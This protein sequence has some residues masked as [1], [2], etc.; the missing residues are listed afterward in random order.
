MISQPLESFIRLLGKGD[1]ETMSL[2]QTAALRSHLDEFIQESDL[3][4]L[5]LLLSCYPTRS[6]IHDALEALLGEA[7]RSIRFLYDSGRCQDRGEDEL[8]P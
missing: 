3:G 1:A 2:T 4:E 7:E 6:S 5:S 8:L